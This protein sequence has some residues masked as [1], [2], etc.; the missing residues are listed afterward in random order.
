[1]FLSSKNEV[2][3]TIANRT[4]IRV[5]LIVVATF[6]G[7]K[8]IGSLSHV[9]TLIFVSVFLA[10]ALNPAVSNVS[11]HLRIK[12]RIAATAV[13][14]IAV[15]LILVTFLSLI[16]PPLV[17]Q[18]TDFVS[19]LPQ[20]IDNFRTQDSSIAHFIRLHKL[21]SELGQVTSELRN[22]IRDLPEPVLATAGR[23]TGTLVSVITVLIMTFMMLVEGPAW[24]RRFWRLQPLE[25]RKQ[26]QEVAMRMYKVVT[27]YVNGQL[28]IA[29]I[30]AL[31]ALVALL[32]ASTALGVSINAVGLAG[33]IALMGL[34]P[35]I[36]NTIG[37]VVVV[38]L[39]LFSS[40]PLAIIMGI[41]F[42]VYQ[43]IENATL[44]P[45]IQSKTNELT[46]LLVFIAA[47][48]GVAAAGILG[49]LI[50]I[51]LAGCLKILLEEWLGDRLPR[52]ENEATISTKNKKT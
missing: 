6:L 40:L 19:N 50:A 21:D 51:P 20:T 31:F 41:F 2:Q 39:C 7:L 37:A 38:I 23:I 49:A 44:Q 17:R 26:R 5:I 10:I 1:M 4:I 27:G 33:I 28:L 35:M 8:L 3:V 43:Q 25:K 29:L 9:L 16:I 24:I 42:L 36:G 14:Y 46:P 32:I 30:A 13:A 52:G 11:K 12:S 45:Y 47:I 48:V 18:T 15:L 34:V 22:H